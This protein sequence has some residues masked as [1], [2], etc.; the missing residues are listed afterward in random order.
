MNADQNRTEQYIHI[1]VNARLVARGFFL[2][3]DAF[4]VFQI[5]VSSA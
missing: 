3:E 4:L 5:R 2:S 1:A